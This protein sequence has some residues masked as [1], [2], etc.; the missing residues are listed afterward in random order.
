[1]NDLSLF[2]AALAVAYLVPGPDMILLLEMSAAQGR[3][4]ALA[5]AV[6]LGLARA[7]HVTLSALGLA[8]LLRSAPWA[9]EAVRLVG[10]GY[11]IWI[12]IAILRSGAVHAGHETAA[13]PAP[14]RLR[15][16]CLRGLITN[17][18]NPKAL[19]FCSVL[20]PQFIRPEMGQ[21]PGQ[22]ALLGVLL[23]GLGAAFDLLYIM[24]GASL[25]R[26]LARHPLAQRIQRWL[27]ASLLFGFSL[28]LAF[29]Q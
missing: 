9:F 19:L 29:T 12:G 4:A 28:R 1:M 23:V 3:V 10:V 18:S 5:G 6:G 22:F 24:T 27:F 25:G 7:T 8:A 14:R 26:W 11:L 17:I 21:V 20:L 2:I 15:A 16:A 13:T